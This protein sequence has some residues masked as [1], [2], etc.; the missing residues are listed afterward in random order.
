MPHAPAA[1]TYMGL[2]VSLLRRAYTALS[3]MRL[4]LTT[5]NIWFA[6]YGTLTVARVVPG[7]H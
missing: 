4:T 3:M 1:T 7:A 2:S 6:G 5:V